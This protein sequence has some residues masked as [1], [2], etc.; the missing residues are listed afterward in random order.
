MPV[1][2]TFP[3]SLII[4]IRSAP[5]R[6]QL[7]F[8]ANWME[9]QKFNPEGFPSTAGL[10]Q[11][12]AGNSRDAAVEFCFKLDDGSEFFFGVRCA[13]G[14]T[15]DQI[16]LFLSNG[17]NCGRLDAWRGFDDFMMRVERAL[18]LESGSLVRQLQNV[19][20]GIVDYWR[21]GDVVEVWNEAANG[22]ASFDELKDV[23]ERYPSLARNDIRFVCLESNFMTPLH[24][25]YGVEISSETDGVYVLDLAAAHRR[26]VENMSSTLQTSPR[27]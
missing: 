15:D 13:D 1:S 7:A 23:L 24:H 11:I 20:I 5:Y 17:L 27:Y 6:V 4:A 26:L 14:L 16:V 3:K 2:F 21:R 22:I 18:T 8:D 25:W 19:E 9:A 10:E 12:V